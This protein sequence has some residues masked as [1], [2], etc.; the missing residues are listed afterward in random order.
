MLRDKTGIG[1]AVHESLVSDELLQKRQIGFN[2]DHIG[3][4]K[5][6]LHT[7][8]R[9]IAISAPGNKF[10]DHR[11]VIDADLIACKGANPDA[12]IQ[13][14]I[15]LAIHFGRGK[16]M[17]P[18]GLRQKI[19]GWIFSADPHLDRVAAGDDFFLF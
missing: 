17:H 1:R 9:L 5:C 14:Y 3:L 4:G 6:H 12:G 7:A 16:N 10:G 13:T 11:I 8:N 2:A 19:I 18:A 15:A